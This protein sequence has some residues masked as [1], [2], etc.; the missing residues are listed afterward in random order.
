M[1]VTEGEFSPEA[2]RL[3]SEIEKSGLP[4]EAKNKIG[5]DEENK[6]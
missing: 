2:S 4:S 6:S 3:T 1:P 5:S